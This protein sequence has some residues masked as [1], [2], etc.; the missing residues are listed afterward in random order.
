MPD[1]LSHGRGIALL[2]KYDFDYRPVHDIQSLYVEWEDLGDILHIIR[3]RKRC[4][5]TEMVMLEGD[6]RLR[7]FTL[8]EQCRFL[9]KED[10]SPDNHPHVEDHIPEGTVLSFHEGPHHGVI[11]FDQGIPLAFKDKFYQVDYD[12]IQLISR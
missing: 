6:Y 3:R 9:L 4:Y 11:D 2:R 10:V 5:V 8:N 7:Y 1:R 12:F